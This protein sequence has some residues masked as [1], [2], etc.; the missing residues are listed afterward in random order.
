MLPRLRGFGRSIRG[1][2][3]LAT[4]CSVAGFGLFMGL[5]A[6]GWLDSDIRRGLL[7][8]ARHELH[9]LGSV[10]G[11]ARTVEDLDRQR[12]A[13]DRLYPEEGVVSLG[14]W[15]REGDLVLGYP[16]VPALHTPW[17]EG[18]RAARAGAIPWQEEAP[19]LGFPARLR[20]AT[21]LDV[22]GEPTWV[23]IVS[24]ETETGEATVERFARSYAFGLALLVMLCALGAY[25]IVSQALKPVLS[26]VEAAQGITA[27]GEALGR[28][29]PQAAGSELAELVLLINQLL[30]DANA[31]V[32]R[33]RRFTAHAG[34]ELRTPL[35]RMRGEVEQALRLGSLDGAISA[36]H[37]VL[38]EVDVQRQVL[39]ALLEL[40]HSGERFD[41]AE[42]PPLDL[43]QLAAEIAEEAEVLLEGGRRLTSEVEPGVLIGGQRALIARALWNLLHNAASYSPAEGTISL[44]VTREGERGRVEV[45]NALL[46]GMSPLE[47]SHFEPFARGEA[48]GSRG[49]GHHGLGLALTRAIAL[50]HG[51][52]LCGGSRPDGTVWLA[53]E[54]PLAP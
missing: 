40:S 7:S 29:E 54:L 13:L 4:V 28:L 42:E 3:T 30:A 2:L 31:T 44:R 20:T 11:E 5:V 51:G 47:E 33:L 16:G 32:T 43:S 46:E 21:S 22:G 52:Q 23:L 14:I 53:L 35:S 18:A 1:R 41:L 24:V 15:S 48:Q 25:L 10:I 36:L 49:G 9:E 45:E 8:F 26:L 50:R 27:G 6:R 38:E 39:D 17:P 12:E 34:H 37:G 19:V